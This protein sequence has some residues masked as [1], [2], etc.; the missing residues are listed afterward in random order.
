[1]VDSVCCLWLPL[2]TISSDRLSS[3]GLRPRLWTRSGWDRCL[4]APAGNRWRREIWSWRQRWRPHTSILTNRPRSSVCMETKRL[5]GSHLA[6]E[7]LSSVHL[8]WLGWSLRNGLDCGWSLPV[9]QL[10]ASVYALTVQ[11]QTH[12]LQRSEGTTADDAK[13]GLRT[14]RGTLGN[15]FSKVSEQAEII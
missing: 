7:P 1:M 8:K 11:F 3:L 9:I 10:S 14:F 5:H 6:S 12:Q 13:M 4:S 15:F 2:S